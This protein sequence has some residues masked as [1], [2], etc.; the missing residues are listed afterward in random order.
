[1]ETSAFFRPGPRARERVRRVPEGVRIRKSKRVGVEEL[2]HRPRPGV[3]IPDAVRQLRSLADVRVV[4]GQRHC[5]RLTAL[6]RPDAAHLPSA[7]K[8]INHS[9]ITLPEWQ[10]VKDRGDKPPANVEVGQPAIRSKVIPVQRRAVRQQRRA[11]SAPV[12]DRL[13]PGEGDRK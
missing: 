12:V 1:M 8:L 4:E 7:G 10:V 3:R 9:G 5:Q 6:H 13:G 11:K 2:L